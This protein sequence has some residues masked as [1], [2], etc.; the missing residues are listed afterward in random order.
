MEEYIRSGIALEM[1]NSQTRAI[2]G[3]I[4]T[5][6]GACTA[7]ILETAIQNLTQYFAFVGV[8]ERFDESLVMLR[9]TFGWRNVFYV[10]ANVARARRQPTAR[11]RELV[12]AHNQLD[13]QLYRWVSDRFDQALCRQPGFQAD[14]RRFV[15]RNALY[16]P[17]G[18]LAHAWPAA[19]RQRVRGART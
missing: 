19:A 14:L 7:D 13:L 6:F 12:E 10:S 8:T 18:T 11:E 3:D 9:A 15:R 17:W 2:A 4:G 1:D 16:Q 5:P